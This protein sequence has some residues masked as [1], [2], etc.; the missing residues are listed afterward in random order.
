MFSEYMAYTE[1]RSVGNLIFYSLGYDK[2]IIISNINN[3]LNVQFIGNHQV[4]HLVNDIYIT[5]AHTD[6]TQPLEAVDK[7]KLKRNVFD[8]DKANVN[9]GNASFRSVCWFS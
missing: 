1:P 3:L 5:S 7:V 6:F 8:D 4:T 2:Y 9:M